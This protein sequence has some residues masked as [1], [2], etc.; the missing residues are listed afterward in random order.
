MTDL[1]GS[2]ID[3][4]L[5][6]NVLLSDAALAAILAAVFAPTS[7]SLVADSD[8]SAVLRL[9]L[10]A[11]VVLA[12]AAVV[13]RRYRA[14]T[15]FA[16]VSAAMLVLLLTPALGGSARVQFGVDVP[17]ILL[18]SA[19]LF[20]VSLYAVA[21]HSGAP[22]PTLALGVGFTG[23]VFTVVRLWSV[24]HWLPGGSGASENASRLLLTAALCG[25]VLA[26]WG[27][28]RFRRVR[29]AYVQALEEQSRRAD[30]DRAERA[31][32]AAAEERA[33]IAREMHD[34]VAHSLS[35]MVSQAEGGR[36]VS[37]HSPD[38]A[39]EVFGTIAGVGRDAM[40]QMRG[41]LGVLHEGGAEQASMSPQ[42]TVADIPAL[43]DRVRG[44][45]LVIELTESGAARALDDAVGLAAY[46]VV[47]E[48]LTNVTKHAGSG[49]S[50]V[51]AV[52][53][54]ADELR[55]EVRD[56]GVGTSRTGARGHGL[57]GMRERLALVGGSLNEG[58]GTNSG[59][60]LSASI[61]ALSTRD[62][63][64]SR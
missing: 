41:L 16:V 22:A 27:L 35:V 56:D 32:R 12:H 17:P 30:A 44:A 43:V 14:R 40:S 64:G 50:A 21:A 52:C 49:A 60:T 55:I 51:V 46:R 39:G 25:C 1:A 57:D 48:G 26:G 9:S 37:R 18:P 54:S 10:I 20:F 31:Q 58:D 59:F 11:A 3:R 19:A 29:S 42:P 23:V 2:R 15:S 38:R 33:R 5:R 36:M 45:G 13:V 63:G 28:G 62:N 8:R 34:V 53:W 7:V 61:P 4:W 24:S 47:Q 6:A